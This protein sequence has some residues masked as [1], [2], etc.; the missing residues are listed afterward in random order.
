MKN[1][2]NIRKTG[3]PEKEDRKQKRTFMRIIKAFLK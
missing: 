3:G 2:A 1:E